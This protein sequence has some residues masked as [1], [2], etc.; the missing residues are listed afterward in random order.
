MGSH[1]YYY[2]WINNGTWT[3]VFITHNFHLMEHGSHRIHLN[4]TETF[5]IPSV[6]AIVIGHAIGRCDSVTDKCHRDRHRR[7]WSFIFTKKFSKIIV[8]IGFFRFEI[9][10]WTTETLV[11][12]LFT[13][14][15]AVAVDCCLRTEHI[16]CISLVKCQQ[17]LNEDRNEKE[18][19]F[20][21]SS[22]AI[23]TS[24]FDQRHSPSA[25]VCSEWNGKWPQNEQSSEPSWMCSK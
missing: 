7:R 20:L 12:L 22:S 21:R 18:N 25:T 23:Y 13:H 4:P 16:V 15:F 24:A 17:F 3:F 10:I 6:Y 8:W 1:C 9:S 19:A 5:N 14:I 11:T 2:Y